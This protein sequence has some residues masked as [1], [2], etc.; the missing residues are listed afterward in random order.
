MLVT[1]TSNALEQG[2]YRTGWSELAHEIN[3]ANV[4]A[5]LERSGGD[6]S[7]Q[8]AFFEA[9]LSVEAEFG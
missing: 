2:G 9:V 6:Q 1:G 4:D 8:L 3:G 7:A 5:E